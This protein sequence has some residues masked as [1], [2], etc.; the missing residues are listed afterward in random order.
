V[1]KENSLRHFLNI[2]FSEG[3]SGFGDSDVLVLV[4]GVVGSPAVLS[5][6]IRENVVEQGAG[7]PWQ[8][9]ERFGA[10]PKFLRLTSFMTLSIF[11]ADHHR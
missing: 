5:L 1:I 11:S 3:G 7:K 2:L 8:Q 6:L 4:V 9:A 10:G